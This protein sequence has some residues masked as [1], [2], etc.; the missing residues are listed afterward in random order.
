MHISIMKHHFIY[1]DMDPE[2]RNDLDLYFIKR[3][4]HLLFVL[5]PFLPSLST[6]ITDKRV[7]IQ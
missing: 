1:F 4:F 5:S 6:L 7:A 2:A 3:R